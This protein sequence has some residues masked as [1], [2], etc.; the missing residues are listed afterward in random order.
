MTRG[1]LVCVD[2]NILLSATDTSRP[3]HEKARAVFSSA[4]RVGIHLTLSGQIIREYLVVSTRPTVVNGLGLPLP[5]ALHN[6][7]QFKRRSVLLEESEAVTMKLLE[8]VRLYGITCK[9]IHDANIVAMMV[10]NGI[11]ALIT[12]N[13]G[14][15]SSFRDITCINIEAFHRELSGIT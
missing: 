11:S 15:F 2:T 14:D 12:Q 9:Q 7:E 3:E 6:I 4:L 10:T 8:L 1:D 5:D 13:T